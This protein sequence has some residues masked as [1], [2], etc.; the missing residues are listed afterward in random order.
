MAG[1]PYNELLAKI[2]TQADADIIVFGGM[3][4]LFD[5]YYSFRKAF[6]DSGSIARTVMFVNQ[7][8]D[9]FINVGNC[10]LIKQNSWR[11]KGRNLARLKFRPPRVQQSQSK[12]FPSL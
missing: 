4:L 10:S 8:C 2:A 11:R 6:E 9:V 5:D 3:G 1:E 7:A 12:Q